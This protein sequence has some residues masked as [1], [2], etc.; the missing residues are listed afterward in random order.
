M[1]RPVRHTLA[2]PMSRSPRSALAAGA[3]FAV[4]G[5]AACGSGSDDVTIPQDNAD[6]MLAEL[7]ELEAAVEADDCTAAVTD[8]TQFVATVNA[9]PK[10]VG[11]EVKTE[12]REAGQDLIAKAQD[13]SQCGDTGEQTTTTET[14]TGATGEFG[15]E[16]G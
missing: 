11:E 14:E 6:A 5:L 7:E 12:L 16:D 2:L 8:A 10:E 4:L 3:A 9:L 1:R 13:P 15:A